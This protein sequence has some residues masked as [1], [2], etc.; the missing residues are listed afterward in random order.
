MI[1]SPLQHK[2][3][4]FPLCTR[5]L[6]AMLK[7]QQATVCPERIVTSQGL[8]GTCRNFLISSEPH[9]YA[10]S[11]F[12]Q[13]GKGSGKGQLRVDRRVQFIHCGFSFPSVYSVFRIQLWLL[14]NWRSELTW[15][16]VVAHHPGVICIQE[17]ESLPPKATAA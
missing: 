11:K 4:K 15:S 3:H 13:R 2:S 9:S 8:L 17:L 12:P 6:L 7:G 5:G 1:A 14:A 16:S 10:C